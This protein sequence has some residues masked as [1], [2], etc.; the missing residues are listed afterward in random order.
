MTQEEIDAFFY[1]EPF[2]QYRMKYP[3]V[4][5]KLYEMSR[6][7]IMDTKYGKIYNKEVIDVHSLIRAEIKLKRTGSIE[8]GDYYRP[9]GFFEVT[10]TNLGDRPR[11]F[12]EPTFKLSTTNKKNE[13]EYIS[14]QADR[15]ISA[16]VKFPVKLNCGEFVTVGYTVHGEYY[17][18]RYKAMLQAIVTTTLGEEYDSDEYPHIC[19][20]RIRLEQAGGMVKCPLFGQPF[21][22]DASYRL[23]VTNVNPQKK[24]IAFNTPSFKLSMP[25]KGKQ[26]FPLEQIGK[27]VE[28]PVTL[29]YG[30][31]VLLSYHVTDIS[32]SKFYRSV[33]AEAKNTGKAT[34]QA[35]LTTLDE[36]C[37]SNACPLMD[38]EWLKRAKFCF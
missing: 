28:F 3:N 15:N 8:Y 34:L 27:P 26:D 7:L 37:H 18:R 22:E 21:Y 1:F 24:P 14:V 11:F 4:T 36:V 5:K 9:K 2:E 12:C 10:I 31:T 23:T 38:I 30:Q 20:V 6:E 19:V 13:K 32:S 25:N 17:C 16:P 35:T 29:K 33:Y